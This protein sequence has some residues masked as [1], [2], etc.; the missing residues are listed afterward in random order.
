LPPKPKPLP[1]FLGAMAVLIAPCVGLGLV[2]LQATSSSV[3]HGEMLLKRRRVIPRLVTMEGDLL[4]FFLRC[5]FTALPA[6]AAFSFAAILVAVAAHR[7]ITNR[8]VAATGL[9]E[10]PRLAV[11]ACLVPF[12]LFLCWFVLLALLPI[13][14]R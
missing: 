4:E 1:F 13:A 10:W 6:L 3:M 14:F 11:R 9:Y 12:A 8:E 2:L 7:T 5:A